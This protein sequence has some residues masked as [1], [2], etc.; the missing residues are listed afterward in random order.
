MK[1]RIL[2]IFIAVGILSLGVLGGIGAQ[3]FLMPYLVSHDPFRQW[4]FVRQLV[5]WNERA[6]VIREVKEVVIRIDD[7]PQQVAARAENVVVGVESR[8][9]DRVIT[10]SGFVI[11]EDGFI[12]TEASVVPQGYETRVYLRDGEGFVG[13]EVLKRDFEQNLAIIKIDEKNMQ[14]AGFASD[15]SIRM[16]SPVVLIAKTIEDGSLITIVNQGTVRTKSKGAVRTNIFDKTTLGGSPLFDLE[17]HIVGLNTFESSGRLVAIPSS[18]LRAFSD[19]K[20]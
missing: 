19:S 13:A 16:G 1:P 4:K 15:D 9:A 14:T 3:A 12:L 17:G 7:A 5:D 18:V 10:G 6:A 8:G 11:Y 2:T 20:R